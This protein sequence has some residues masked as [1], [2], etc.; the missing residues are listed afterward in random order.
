MPKVKKAVVYLFLVLV[1]VYTALSLMDTKGE[2]RVEQRVWQTNKKLYDAVRN[3]EAVPD[4]VFAQI[5]GQYEQILRDFPNSQLIPRVGILLGEVYA[6]QKDYE[7]ARKKFKNVCPGYSQNES[8]CAEAKSNIGKTYEFQDDWP[9]ALEVYEGVIKDYSVTDT[10]LLLPMHIGDYYRTHQRAPDARQAYDN[11]ALH[12]AR[13]SKQHPNS[14]IEFKSLR[15]QA[16][17]YLIQERWNEA[18]DALGQ[19]LFKFPAYP[20]TTDTIR[21]INAVS[22]EKLKN[23][24]RAVELYQRFIEKNPNHALNKY[25]QQ[26]LANL[27]KLKDKNLNS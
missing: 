27:A 21:M 18:V 12:Y 22:V 26:M 9:N 5:A 17:C 19:L 3:R 8:I 24:A 11:A 2:Y 14:T 25:L 20:M 13:I 1:G 15:L 4:Q 6:V 7:T 23:P 16:D 10:G